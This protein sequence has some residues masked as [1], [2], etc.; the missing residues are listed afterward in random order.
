MVKDGE[1]ILEW[2]EPFSNG[3]TI[4]MYTVYHGTANNKNWNSIKNLT[5]V[6]RRQYTVKVAMGKQYKVLVTATN[7]Y[8]ESSKEG[9]VLVYVQGGEF[10]VILTD[11]LLH[12]SLKNLPG[13]LWFCVFELQFF[14]F[15]GWKSS[16][17]CD[18]LTV[19]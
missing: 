18:C 16:S 17:M 6:S 12:R 3:A 19:G 8:G 5:D 14:K 13:V 10:S 11:C 1:L 15:L 4:T 9:K 2:D 7:K